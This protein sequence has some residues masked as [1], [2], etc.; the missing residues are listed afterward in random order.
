MF[1]LN[2]CLFAPTRWFNKFQEE[3]QNKLHKYQNISYS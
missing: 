3:T 1:T 2:V